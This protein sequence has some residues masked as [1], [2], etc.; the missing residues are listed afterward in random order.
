MLVEVA[1]QAGAKGL[2]Y[3]CCLGLQDSNVTQVSGNGLD[4]L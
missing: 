2:Q 3:V 1:E 4:A